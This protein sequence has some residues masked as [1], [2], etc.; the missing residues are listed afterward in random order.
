MR[1]LKVMDLRTVFLMLFVSL[2]SVASYAQYDAVVAKDG[3]GNFTT[4]QA[5]IDA[6]PTGRTTPY[7]IFIKN[8]KYQE[9]VTIPSTKPFLQLIGESAANTIISYDNYSGKLI[10]GGGGAT[11]GTN[12]SATMFINANDCALFNLSIENAAGYLGDG[13]Q[14]VAVYLTGDRVVF[15]NCRLNS[16]QDTLW[17]NGTGRQYF[18]NCYIDGNTDFIFGSSTAVFDSCVI[19]GRDRIDGGSG[20][21]LTAAAT[22][23]SQPYGEVFRDCQ[24]PRNRGVTTYTLGRPWQNEPKTVFLNTRMGSSIHPV[25]WSTWNISPSL[26]TYAEYKSRY[27]NG[28]LIDTSQRLDWSR[29]LTDAEAAAYYNNSNL[30]GAWDPCA[31][32]TGLCTYT[33]PEIAISNFRV[34]R[35]GSNSTISWNISWPIADVTY[36]LYRST[37]SANYT[38]VHSMTSVTDTLVAYSHSDGLPAPGTKYFYY[39][40]ASKAGMAA[41]TTDVAVVNVNVP[42][43]GEYRSANSGPWSNTVTGSTTISGGSVTAVT[44]TASPSFATAPTVTFANAPAGGTTATGTAVLDA[45]GRVTSINITNPGS[46]YTS[47]P[48]LTWNYTGAGGV[49]VWEVYSASSSTWNPVNIGTGPSNVNVTVRTGDTVTINALVGVANLTI[50]NGGVL[51]SISNAMQGQTQTIRVGNGTAPV[52]AFIRNDGVFGSTTG[53]NDGIVVEVATVCKNLT[54]L[55]SGITSIARMRPLPNNPNS[56]HVV[57]DK[58]VDFNMSNNVGLTGYYNN[59]SNLNSEVVTI[60]INQGRTVRNTQPGSGFHT[61]TSTS[62][63]MGTITYNVFGTLDLSAT[64]SVAFVPNSVNPNSSLTMNIGSDGLLK[65]G[66]SFTMTNTGGTSWGTSKITIAQGGLVDATKTTNLSSSNNA[67]SGYF[68]TYGGMIKRAVAATDVVFPVGTSSTSYNP[69]TI[70]NSGTADNFSVSVQSAFSFPVAD[71]NKVVNMQ[72]NISE[73]VP[74]GSNATLSLAWTIADQAPGFDPT[75]PVFIIYHNGSSWQQI[76]ATITGAGTAASPYVATASGITTF[77]PFGVQNDVPVLPLSFLSFDAQHNQSSGAVELRWKTTNEVNTSA[78]I[79]ERSNGNNE[80]RTIGKVEAKNTAGVNEYAFADASP[81]NGTSYYRLK[82]VDKDNRFTYS[83][84]EIINLKHFSELAAFPNPIVGKVWVSYP[85]AEK[86][87]LK[88]VTLDGSVLMTTNLP[89]NSASRELNLEG[90]AT[91]AYI[92]VYEN[93]KTKQTIRLMK[94]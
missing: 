13:P 7:T 74:G 26:V 41:D 80:F 8:G 70:N 87:Q 90:F 68:L 77:S 63:Q 61:G 84:I 43:N 54:L 6:A 11:Y 16:G 89:A 36:E 42:L 57:F 22:T 46:G 71:A 56:L 45:N 39:L 35:G 66:T 49:S 72:W 69:A 19:Y 91:G 17:H 58:N 88:L 85:V 15:K 86:A 47:A 51:N 28:T 23:T 65:L 79:V 9:V 73:D 60:T 1:K 34:Q 78:F 30:F 48:A 81:A 31:V 4:V 93:G 2:L 14:A 33:A 59:G 25:G 32:W 83:E 67:N 94:L 3:S 5:A 18:K 55:G 44:I 40:R 20:G 64:N 92:L 53:T 10:P 82:Q 29:Q 38:L 75:Q 52:T 12:N 24:I 62:N 50:E 76:P 37:D 27:Y 21:Y